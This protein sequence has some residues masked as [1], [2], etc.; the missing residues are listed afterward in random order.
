MEL[1]SK[2]TNQCPSTGNG[3]QRSSIDLD[4]GTILTFASR[5]VI[6]A[7]GSWSDICMSGDKLIHRLWPGEKVV[8]DQGYRGSVWHMA[9]D[10][11]PTQ[12]VAL[13]RMKLKARARHE[14]INRKLKE[15]KWLQMK[16]RHPHRK[17]HISF[18]AVANHVQIK[19]F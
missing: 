12:N 7:C 5:Q 4:Y 9:P 3:T 16:W 17:H 19:L 15:F 10:D 11:S 18:G 13:E 6:F 14:T 1:I 2:S 8:A